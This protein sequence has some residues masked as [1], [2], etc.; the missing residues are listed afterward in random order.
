MKRVMQK[1]AGFALVLILPVCFLQGPWLE[2]QTAGGIVRGRVLDQKGA[3]A[4]RVKVVVGAR[5]GFTDSTGRYVLSRVPPGRYKV[6]LER[7][8]KKADVQEIEV[9][10]P[11]TVQDLTWPFS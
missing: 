7:A 3:P 1:A 11:V 2:A 10:G 6:V 5:W 9:K 4:T 8:G